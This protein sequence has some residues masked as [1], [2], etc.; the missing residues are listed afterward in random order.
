MKTNKL[1]LAAM[2]F[3]AVAMVS[4]KEKKGPRTNRT[5]RTNRKNRK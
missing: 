4:C 1:M 2:L 3:G 5:N